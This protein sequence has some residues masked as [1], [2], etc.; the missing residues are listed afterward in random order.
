MLAW[1]IPLLFDN[2]DC[3]D[4]LKVKDRRNVTTMKTRLD[5]LNIFLLSL[6]RLAGFISLAYLVS[7]LV[8]EW[9]GGVNPLIEFSSTGFSRIEST[10]TKNR[11][12]LGVAY[13]ACKDN[14]G[15]S[16]GSYEFLDE[17]YEAWNLSD[18]RFLIESSILTA[19]ES[20]SPVRAN[21]LCRVLKTQDDEYFATHWKVQG[22]Q[23]SIL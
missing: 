13:Q 11:A 23:I 5:H 18:G 22:I 3:R 6:I 4:I 21:L 20:G 7:L 1:K 15:K 17:T 19:T 2:D 10:D 14:L 12:G 8:T 16:T 9:Y